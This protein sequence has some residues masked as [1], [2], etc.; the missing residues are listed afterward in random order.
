MRGLARVQSGS[1]HRFARE[2]LRRA[3]G[4]ASARCFAC[5]L[6]LLVCCA[7]IRQASGWIRGGARARGRKS[8]R[9]PSPILSSRFYF[10]RACARALAYTSPLSALRFSRERDPMISEFRLIRPASSEIRTLRNAIRPCRE[11]NAHDEL[12]VDSRNLRGDG[13]DQ[14]NTREREKRKEKG[15]SGERRRTRFHTG[16]NIVGFRLAQ[17][18]AMFDLSSIKKFNGLIIRYTFLGGIEI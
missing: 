17:S 4:H 2:G 10:V 18:R 16:N 9:S 11:K 6:V 1:I 13:V 5:E 12:L 14:K 7:L 3:G 8:A 15:Q